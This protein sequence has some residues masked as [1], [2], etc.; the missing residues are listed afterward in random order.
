VSTPRPETRARELAPLVQHVLEPEP[1][2][3]RDEDGVEGPDGTRWTLRMKDLVDASGLQRQAIHFYI[4]EG[5]LPPGLKSSRNAAW[6]GETHLARLSLIKKLQ[7]ERFLPLRAIK[8][9]LSEQDESFSRDQQRF[10]RALKAHATP[11]LRGPD[12]VERIPLARLLD[13]FPV[14]A[15]EAE[16]LDR[17][18]LAPILDAPSSSEGDAGPFIAA[19]DAWVYEILGELR[20]LGFTEEMGFSVAD[21]GLYEEAISTLFERE[22]ALL[23]SR[24]TRFP[25]DKAAAMVERVLPLV[26]RFLERY[27]EA[28]IRRFFA[29]WE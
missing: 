28:K 27:H 29:A 6:Y 10:I 8:A 22:K 20:Q 24:L 13:A 17:L 18:G 7:H 3:P 14:T 9:V 4:K 16:E 15:A 5:L 21:L 19:S 1:P 11:S 12:T 2:A 23:A 26:H 25:A